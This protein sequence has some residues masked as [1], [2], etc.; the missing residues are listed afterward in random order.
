[1][2]RRSAR[3]DHQRACAERPVA[4]SLC[5]AAHSLPPRQLHAHLE[6]VLADP[7]RRPF[8]QQQVTQ[9]LIK[10]SAQALA[11]TTLFS[12]FQLSR[13]HAA[14]PAG[15]PLYG[16]QLHKGDVCDCMDVDGVWRIGEVMGQDSTGR[17]VLMHFGQWISGV[18][19]LGART[20]TLSN[21]H[22]CL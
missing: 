12:H 4:C 18:G 3:A 21:G 8:V 1:V 5:F 13:A 22:D 14:Q 2:Y 11:A 20:C 9:L 16:Y 15:V 6:A 10:Q 19:P 7:Q 17:Y